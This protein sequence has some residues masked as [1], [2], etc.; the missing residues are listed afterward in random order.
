MKWKILDYIYRN[1]PILWRKYL[2]SV[3]IREGI[4]RHFEGDANWKKFL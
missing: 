1:H 4:K 3:S 2:R